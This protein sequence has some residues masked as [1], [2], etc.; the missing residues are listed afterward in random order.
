ML[1]TFVFRLGTR[2]PAKSSNMYRVCLAVLAVVSQGVLADI[3]PVY[4]G[5]P[6]S[7][8]W[9]SC[10][11][12]GPT[13]NWATDF[14]N[15]ENEHVALAEYNKDPIPGPSTQFIVEGGMPHLNGAGELV[16]E[17]YPCNGPNSIGCGTI[18]S[19]S[20]AILYG[21]FSATLLDEIDLEI[22]GKDQ[23]NANAN[24]WYRGSE[25]LD[26]NGHNVNGYTMRT[27]DDNSVNFHTYTI[28]WNATQISWA[29]DGVVQHTSYAADSRKGFPSTPSRISFGAW[30]TALTSTWAGV[31]SS[32]IYPKN[33]TS[34]WKSMNISCAANNGPP[35]VIS[36]RQPRPPIT[37]AT[38]APMADV[39]GGAMSMP[40]ATFLMA[41]T[42][43]AWFT[44]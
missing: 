3:Q 14:A 28:D 35:A 34:R 33:A 10:L 26:A 25:L 19:T 29:I 36:K 6:G 43:T 27:V 7:T 31:A 38:T 24:W 21:T 40:T 5:K 2:S 30:E 9:S 13:C 17:V 32:G 37:S 11:F 23:T 1:G 15:W 16:M 41:V 39:G 20:R 18:I 4:C 12:D 8:E 42:L 22:T 44:L